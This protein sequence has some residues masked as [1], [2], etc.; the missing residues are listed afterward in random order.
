[1]AWVN[2]RTSRLSV[3]ADIPDSFASSLRRL[4]RAARR[5]P[6]PTE[7]KDRLVIADR[8]PPDAGFRNV[9]LQLV[10]LLGTS[11]DPH[12]PWRA[13]LLATP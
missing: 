3:G 7:A 4:R 12:G 6:A 5:S 10:Y 2:L 1:M 9:E 11:K 8:L 13:A